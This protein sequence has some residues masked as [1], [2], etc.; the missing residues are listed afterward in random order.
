M[1]NIELSLF[2]LVLISGL[3]LLKKAH[4]RGIKQKTKFEHEAA[5]SLERN[6]KEIKPQLKNYTVYCYI[7]LLGGKHGWSETTYEKM[8]YEIIQNCTHNVKGEVYLSSQYSLNIN[9]K[10]K[11]IHYVIGNKEYDF[12][13]NK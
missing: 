8:K 1:N 6:L 5:E 10:L 3:I 4:L 12:S 7:K 11:E 9:K 13:K 2:L